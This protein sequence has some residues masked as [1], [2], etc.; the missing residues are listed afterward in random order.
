MYRLQHE[1]IY[2]QVWCLASC[3]WVHS[4]N[5]AKCSD[6]K[7]SLLITAVLYTCI[8]NKYYFC[9]VTKESYRV[10]GLNVRQ[11]LN[12]RPGNSSIQSA[13]YWHWA[14]FIKIDMK[15]FILKLFHEN[16]VRKTFKAYK[17]SQASVN[18]HMRRLTN[19]KLNWSASNR[20]IG[21]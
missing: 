4:W 14:S 6:G 18:L 11:V 21:V 15:Q 19:V 5:Y 16:P 13:T 9:A 8:N 10:W 3:V 17:G 2:C 1:G 12:W 7:L 20:I